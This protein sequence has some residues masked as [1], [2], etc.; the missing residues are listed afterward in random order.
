MRDKEFKAFKNQVEIFSSVP[1]LVS[2]DG[3][4]LTPILELTDKSLPGV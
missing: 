2:K 1:N 4:A 3:Q